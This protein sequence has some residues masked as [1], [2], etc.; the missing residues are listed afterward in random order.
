MVAARVFVRFSHE[1]PNPGEQLLYNNQHYHSAASPVWDLAPAPLYFT[2][3]RL[4]RVC[5][6]LAMWERV[7]EIA[8]VIALLWLWS[9]YYLRFADRARQDSQQD[10]P[11][12]DSPKPKRNEPPPESE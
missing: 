4:N 7:G 2:T 3:F 11:A 12:R 9:A 1:V 10:S 8:I 6:S 5:R